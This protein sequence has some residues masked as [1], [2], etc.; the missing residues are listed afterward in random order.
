M[1]TAELR[2]PALEG[3]PPSGLDGV[4]QKN[5]PMLGTM[6]F[7]FKNPVFDGFFSYV[8]AFGGRVNGEIA[9]PFAAA[10]GINPR[11]PETWVDEFDTLGARVGAIADEAMA[12]GHR[13]SARD[14]YQRASTYHRWSLACLSPITETDR[15]RQIAEVARERFRQA[16]VLYDP[17]IE[18][19]EVP[20]DG[21]MLSGYFI[22]PD[23]TAMPRKT[24]IIAGGGESVVEDMCRIW[25]IGDQER[26]YNI[27]SV[28]LPGQGTTALDGAIMSPD[29][30]RPM[31]AVIDYA[32]SR[33][34]VDPD[35][36]AAWGGSFGGY[37]LARTAAHDKRLKAIITDSMILDLHAYVTQAKE[38]TRLARLE[39]KAWFRLVGPALNSWSG[40]ALSQMDTW[41]WKW[42][43]ATMAE[44]F[45]MLRD[46]TADPSQITCPTLLQIGADE[47]A[48]PASKRF[49]HEALN[50]I[51]DPNVK[52]VIGPHELGAS[53]KNML[54]NLT[55]IRQTAFDWLDEL[56]EA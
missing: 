55:M 27:L 39:Q 20:F 49:Q 54:P 30:E 6:R 16:A 40:G 14:A 12:R 46:Y 51:D 43:A 7:H 2:Q 48:Y 24:L 10:R 3:S 31:S 4:E 50:K 28:D 1:S 37:I 34:E 33:P 18:T 23:D 47:Y 21:Q 44:W 17:P 8:L 13:I 35:R 42:R 19:I 29:A 22:R 53:G 32:L 38:M 11:R 9:E 26:G 52:L 15:Y 45:E 56:F 25:G 5:K 41:K 36:L